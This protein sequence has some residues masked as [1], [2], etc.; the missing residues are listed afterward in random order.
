MERET[1]VLRRAS[2]GLSQ[3]SGGSKIEGE[4]ATGSRRLHRF[5]E[6]LP[7]DLSQVVLNSDEI[8]RLRGRALPQKAFARKERWANTKRAPWIQ[9]GWRV[10]NVYLRMQIVV[11]RRAG[12]SVLRN[13][14]RYIAC[15][16]DGKKYPGQPTARELKEWMRLCPR[17][18]W[19]FEGTVLYERGGGWV[20]LL[21]S[22]DRAEVEHDYANCKREL[23]R[24]KKETNG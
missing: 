7:R 10:Q 11:F 16:L 12:T 2:V 14:G 4:A 24:Y 18:G 20:E 13:I 15:L 8:S 6:E 23:L 19:Y 22:N 17:L 9:A 5:F 21:A 3:D 1:V